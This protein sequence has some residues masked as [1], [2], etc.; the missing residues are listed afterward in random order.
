VLNDRENILRALREKPLK[1]REV[2]K[3]AN[4]VNEEG[5]PIPPVENA[6]R[7]LGEVRYPQRAMAHRMIR[8]IAATVQR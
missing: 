8:E 7:W 5:L 3:R 2:M 4:V 1:V 6:R